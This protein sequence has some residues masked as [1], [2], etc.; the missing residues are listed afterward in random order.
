MNKDLGFLGA[1]KAAE[2]ILNGTYIFPPGTDPHTIGLLKQLGAAANS[3][4]SNSCQAT[5]S[6]EDFISY[7][8]GRKEKTS[9]SFSG[10]HFGHWKAAAQSKNLSIIHAKSIELAFATG[11]PLDRWIIGL[12]VMLEKKPGVIDVDKLRAILLMEADFNFANHLFFGKRLRASAEEN[13]IFSQ[14][15]FG[16]RENNSS[17]EV[18]LCRLLF[19]DMVRQLKF[20]AALG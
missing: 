6:A 20:N 3:I 19:F 13:N 16:S 4:R 17:I 7:W 14:D 1:T 8:N 12:S 11:T 18:S 2:Q 15:T 9:S 5:I 10:L